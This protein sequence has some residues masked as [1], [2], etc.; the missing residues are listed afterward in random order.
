MR[1]EQLPQRTVA[2]CVAT[3]VL[4]VAGFVATYVLTVR[5]ELGRQLADAAFRGA[6][7]G[8]SRTS[9][10]V[11]NVLGVVSVA[12]LLLAVALIAFV[13]LVRLQRALGLVALTLLVTANLSAQLLKW[14]LDRPDLG[15]LE[16][17]PATLNSLPSGH[18][19]AAFSVVA[20]L[21]IVVPRA[22]QALVV[23]A[24]GGY[25]VL[26]AAATM[27]AGWHRWADSVA[28]LLLVGFW[29]VASLA[30]LALV[31]GPPNRTIRR[32][33]SVRKW[34]AWAAA[35][36]LAGGLLLLAPLAASGRVRVSTLGQVVAFGA[37]MAFILAAVIAML[38]LV[39]E[40]IDRLAGEHAPDPERGP[41]HVDES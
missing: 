10:V 26:T 23:V 18:A 5:T 15:L 40:A 11:D 25:A 17:T 24:G 13:A 9:D 2:W 38:L 41:S 14:L 34:W 6:L 27:F 4:C 16:Y 33:W 20:A 29:A 3:M 12:S 7:L 32:G 8:Q 36:C 30:A 1:V 28:A 39:L 22:L 21:L 31:E 35:V 19:T 37:G